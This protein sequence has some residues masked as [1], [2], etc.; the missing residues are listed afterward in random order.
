MQGDDLPGNS[1]PQAR[2]SGIGTT[3]FVQTE[4]F[5]KNG[6]KLLPGNGFPPVTEKE[7]YLIGF[8][9]YKDIDGSVRITVWAVST[10]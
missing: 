4:K 1:Q 8:L 9:F 7:D 6:S 2:A 5:I 3:G 10:G